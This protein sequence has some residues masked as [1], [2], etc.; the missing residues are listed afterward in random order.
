MKKTLI[1]KLG[2]SE[3]LDAEISRVSSLGDVLRTTVILHHFRDTQ[4][5]WLVDEKAYALLDGNPLIHRILIYDLT[6]VLQLQRERYDTVINFE[7]VPGL[8]AL[9]DSISA[10]QRFGFRFDAESGE[11][12]AYDGCERA[13]TLCRS[14][15]E[16][17]AHREPWQKILLES[18]GGKWRAQP[19]ILGYQPKSRVTQD[20][21]LNHA[22]GGK[23]PTKAWP[24]EYWR[25]L[26]G[27]LEVRASVSWQQGFDNLYEYIDWV[28]SCR[29]I[30]TCDSLGLHIALA[31][32]K[33]VVVLYGPTNSNETYLYDRGVGLYPMGYSCVPCFAPV[34]T[35]TTHCL[36]T[37]LPDQVFQAVLDAQRGAPVRAEFAAPLPAD[38]PIEAVTR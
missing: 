27:M 2:Y 1:I 10:W 33:N 31:L 28:H 29:T 3:T 20:V 18:I 14:P 21:G 23:W 26:A 16:K 17:R 30:V 32:K 24:E 11:A 15:A 4:V 8:C 19:Y 13:F 9:A 22:V 6:S 38:A 34:C 25:Q 5:T 35:Q 37:I 12:R 7:K 36:R